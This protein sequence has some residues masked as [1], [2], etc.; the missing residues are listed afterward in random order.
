MVQK[1]EADLRTSL[2]ESKARKTTRIGAAPHL[3]PQPQIY[4][5]RSTPKL[6]TCAPSL[7]SPSNM[8]YD[9]ASK[10]NDKRNGN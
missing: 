2:D 4:M 7:V 1:N 8:I 9:R 5:S 6:K 3:Q 10:R